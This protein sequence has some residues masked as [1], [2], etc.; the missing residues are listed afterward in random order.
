MR[1]II[2]LVYQDGHVDKVNRDVDPC[3]CGMLELG[4]PPDFNKSVADYVAAQPSPRFY[5]THLPAQH[6]PAQVWTKKPKVKQDLGLLEEEC[7]SVIKRFSDRLRLLKTYK[8]YKIRMSKEP[9]EFQSKVVVL[10]CSYYFIC[11]R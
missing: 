8:K 11:L 3:L 10:F 1:E 4:H 7:F 6:L 5:Y 2:L 9:L